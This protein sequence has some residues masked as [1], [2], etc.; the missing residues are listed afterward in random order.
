MLH[1]ISRSSGV[2]IHPL[3]LFITVCTILLPVLGWVMRWWPAY[4][5]IRHANSTHV[6]GKD[7][8]WGVIRGIKPGTVY[9]L[10]VMAHSG[11]GNG[12]KSPTLFFTLG[13]RAFKYQL[14]HYLRVGG[15]GDVRYCLN[16]INM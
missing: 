12:K 16:Y 14:T 8:T 1:Y 2:L 9:A 13:K 11:A 10:R 7:R 5:D 3:Y 4:E 15:S 6:E